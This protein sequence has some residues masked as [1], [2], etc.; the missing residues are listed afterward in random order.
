[1]IRSKLS[2]APHLRKHQ[3]R[4]EVTDSDKLARLMTNELKMAYKIELMLNV[5]KQF[6]LCC[7]IS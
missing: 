2:V 6:F 7:K 1:M 3:T 4:V 5:V